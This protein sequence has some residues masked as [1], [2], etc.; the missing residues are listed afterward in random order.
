MKRKT[1]KKEETNK[2]IVTKNNWKFSFVF[3]KE[4]SSHHQLTHA[5]HVN[6]RQK[7][8]LLLML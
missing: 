7:K 2:L 3:L 8:V 1:K 5:K 4:R 6:V